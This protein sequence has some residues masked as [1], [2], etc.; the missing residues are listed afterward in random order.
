VFTGKV[1][2]QLHIPFDDPAEAVGTEEEVMP[3]FRRVRDEIRKEFGE[4]YKVEIE[5]R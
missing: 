1:R 5:H 2:K 3:V 4:F